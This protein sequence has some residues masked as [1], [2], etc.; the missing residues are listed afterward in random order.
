MVP[1][2][3]PMAPY[4]LDRDA[5][6]RQLGGPLVWSKSRGQVDRSLQTVNPS[7]PLVD[8]LT[9]RD[10]TAEALA[11]ILRQEPEPRRQE[12]KVISVRNTGFP[13]L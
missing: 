12:V 13:V 1:Q 6:S 9:G 2:L 8:R 5:N 3:G 11:W 4:F 10:P 7:D